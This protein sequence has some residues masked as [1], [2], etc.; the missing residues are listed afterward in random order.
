[1]SSSATAAAAIVTAWSVKTWPSGSCGVGS[2]RGTS[3]TSATPCAPRSK[4]PEASRPP[5]TSTSAPGTAGADP[6]QPED[7]GQRHE[8]DEQRRAVSVVQRPDPG[9]EFAPRVLALRVG[10]RQLRQ[11]ADH[12][13]DRRTRQEPGHHRLG[14]ELRDAPELEDGHQQ[15]QS[16]GGQRDRRDELRGLIALQPGRDHRAARD[17]R[18]R[19]ARARWRSAARCRT[20]RRTTRPPPPRTGR[21]AVARRRCPRSRGPWGRSAR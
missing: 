8:P 2:P 5:T 18:Q 12:H 17:R 3:P 4:T 6:A 13:V 19:R 10:A 20:R 14:Q 21:S 16:A 11:L 7:H 1:M 15:E 9:P